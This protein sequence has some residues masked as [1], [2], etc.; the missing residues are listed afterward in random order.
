MD[1]EECL[2]KIDIT[3]LNVKQDHGIDWEIIV[4]DV[5]PPD[6]ILEVMDV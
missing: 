1:Y 3:G 5:I 6:R 4:K 2:L